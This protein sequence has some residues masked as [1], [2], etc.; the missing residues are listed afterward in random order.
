MSPDK[1]ADIQ[2]GD[3][4]REQNVDYNLVQ[5]DSKGNTSLEKPTDYKIELR[6]NS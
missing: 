3:K 2:Y 1:K 5:I 4:A 6:E